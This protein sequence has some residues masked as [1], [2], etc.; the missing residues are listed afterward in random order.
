MGWLFSCCLVAGRESEWVGC[1]VVLLQGREREWVGCLVVVLLQGENASG[2][3][4]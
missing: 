4:V 3:V 1:L 2:L